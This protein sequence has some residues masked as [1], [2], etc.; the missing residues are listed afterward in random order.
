MGTLLVV[1]DT[2]LV[3]KPSFE[4]NLSLQGFWIIPEA[5]EFSM[6]ASFAR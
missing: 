2:E 1:R 6:G 5:I 4:I 3:S